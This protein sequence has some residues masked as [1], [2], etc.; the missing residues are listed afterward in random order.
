M[1]AAPGE[2]LTRTQREDAIKRAL[3]KVGV[4]CLLTSLTTA[5]GFGSLYVAEMP[6]IQSF[7]YF[8]GL[9]ILFAYGSILFIIPLCL[10]F[11][12]GVPKEPKGSSPLLD[13][14]L[15]K[16]ARIS[17]YRPISVLVVTTL[18]ISGCVYLGSFVVLDNQ[19]TNLL[20]EEHPTSIANAVLDENLGGH[21]TF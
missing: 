8:A 9:G 13:R 21:L 4:A 19:I 10:S 1:L 18:I 14:V 2:R 16:C 15:M 11:V 12:R 3:S 20:D 5:V 7:G 6:T 17:I